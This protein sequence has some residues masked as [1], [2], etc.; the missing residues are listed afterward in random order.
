VVQRWHQLPLEQAL[1]HADQVRSL[2]Q[3]LADAVAEANGFSAAF[4]PD[5]GPGVLMDQLTVMVLDTCAAVVTSARTS[6]LAPTLAA[7][8]GKDLVNLRLQLG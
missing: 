3:S 6:T 2:V 1:L 5:C 7:T 8:L 4:V